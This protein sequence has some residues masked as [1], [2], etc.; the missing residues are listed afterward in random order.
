MQ[1]ATIITST[2]TPSQS[3]P[4]LLPAQQ[5]TGSFGKVE[6]V[7]IGD[8]NETE[9]GWVNEEAKKHKNAA[10]KIK[11]CSSAIK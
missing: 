8:P 7:S 10:A 5:G 1:Q 3:R 2:L 11:N 6:R 4:L 9:L